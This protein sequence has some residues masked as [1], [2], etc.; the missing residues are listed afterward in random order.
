MVVSLQFIKGKGKNKMRLPQANLKAKDLAKDFFPRKE[1]VDAY[2][3]VGQGYERIG[4]DRLWDIWYAL[5]TGNERLKE[6]PIEQSINN[7][8]RH[9][10]KDGEFL[11]FQMALTAKNWKG[12][13]VSFWYDQGG[14]IDHYPEFTKE[15]D[16][17]TD[18]VV[19]NTTQI[20]EL[21]TLYTIPW[22]KEKFNE[23]EPY[24]SDIIGFSIE[25]KGTA[26]RRY[27]CSLEEFRDLE[28]DELV[29]ARTAYMFTDY[30]RTRQLAAAQG[31]V[32]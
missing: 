25:G 8:M 13:K 23:L 27:S 3:A 29:K 17:Q 19:S 1:I 11:T 15:I 24:F 28:W 30:Y 5:V 31:G 22:S 10:N 20:N 6:Q 26:S 21:K 2:N 12:N 4:P 7:V 14:R 18:E 32:K 9:K 16:P